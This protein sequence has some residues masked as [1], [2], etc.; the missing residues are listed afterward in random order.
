MK[1]TL[2]D[3]LILVFIAAILG[4]ILSWIYTQVPIT[5]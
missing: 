5:I 4:I 1:F 2:E 3:I